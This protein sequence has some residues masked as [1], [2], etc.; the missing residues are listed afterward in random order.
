[1][2]SALKF[3]DDFLLV[4]IVFADQLLLPNMMTNFHRSKYLLKIFIV[5][6]IFQCHQ[7]FAMTKMFFIRVLFNKFI[8]VMGKK[9]NTTIQ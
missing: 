8:N 6:I 9:S 1:M 4:R 5:V 2:E 3:M 7:M